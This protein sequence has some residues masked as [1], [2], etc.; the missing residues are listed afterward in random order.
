MR[1]HT[2]IQQRPIECINRLRNYLLT[3]CMTEVLIEHYE[4]H[5]AVILVIGFHVVHGEAI[6]KADV[7]RGIE[8]PYWL[9]I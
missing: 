3:G 8:H 1:L 5:I 9:V 6:G 7:E 4:E 2:H